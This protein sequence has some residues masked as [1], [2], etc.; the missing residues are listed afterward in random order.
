MLSYLIQVTFVSSDDD[1]DFSF[2]E[3][4][5]EDY[6]SAMMMAIQ[7]LNRSG[8]EDRHIETLSVSVLF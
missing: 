8:V 7:K 4:L 2:F 6:V 3:V 5:A 1:D